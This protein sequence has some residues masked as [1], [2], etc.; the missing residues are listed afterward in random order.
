[1][2][3]NCCYI[4]FYDAILVDQVVPLVFLTWRLC[5]LLDRCATTTTGLTWPSLPLQGWV[6]FTAASRLPSPVS[7]RRTG[8]KQ[9]R[10]VSLFCGCVGS[11][12]QLSR[13]V[14]SMKLS[15]MNDALRPQQT[16]TSF[17]SR[18]YIFTRYS[19]HVLKAPIIISTT[20]GSIWFSCCWWCFLFTFACQDA[21]NGWMN[22]GI[23]IRSSSGT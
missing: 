8:S 12:F 15:M 11:C 5:F 18:F 14:L 23:L 4:Q 20:I 21:G 3:R 16:G 2:N 10:P 1:M 13:F 6:Q 17:R 19:W 7:R 22:V 9:D